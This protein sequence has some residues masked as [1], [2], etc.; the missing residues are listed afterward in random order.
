M[1][2]SAATKKVEPVNTYVPSSLVVKRRKKNADISVKNDEPVPVTMEQIQKK[3]IM[4]RSLNDNSKAQ[5]ISELPKTVP[6]VGT[7]LL[8][9]GYSDSDTE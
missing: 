8:D 6:A 4:K 5:S 2:K 1:F 9:V 3:T 7:S